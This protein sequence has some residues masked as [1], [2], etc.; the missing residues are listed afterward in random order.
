MLRILE[1]KG[2]ALHE[3]QGRAF[4][5][6]AVLPRKQARQ[7][8]IRWLVSQLLDDSQD[9]LVLNNSSNITTS[10][11]ENS[12]GCAKNW[13]TTYKSHVLSVAC[14]SVSVRRMLML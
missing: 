9:L 2:Y 14:D 3:N 13:T 12:P 10:V 8:A 6:T 5:Y 4:V 11:Q 7:S 1:K